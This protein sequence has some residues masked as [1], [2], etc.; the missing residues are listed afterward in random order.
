MYTLLLYKS[1]VGNLSFET[2]HPTHLLAILIL[3]EKTPEYKTVT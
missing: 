2:S 3:G 1:M